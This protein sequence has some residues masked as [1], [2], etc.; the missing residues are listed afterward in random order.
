[1][2]LTF[3]E[4][5]RS[6]PPCERPLFKFPTPIYE[7]D[8]DV[9]TVTASYLPVTAGKVILFTSSMFAL[10]YAAYRGEKTSSL[11]SIEYLICVDRSAAGQIFWNHLGNQICYLSRRQCIIHIQRFIR[12][13]A[14]MLFTHPRKARDW[15]KFFYQDLTEGTSWLSSDARFRKIQQIFANQHFVFVHGD[16][17]SSECTESIAAKLQEKGLLL[18]AV[19]ISN[20]KE[21]AEAE[22]LLSNL[23]LGLSQ[24]LPVV[25]QDTYLIDTK[26][27]WGGIHHHELLCQ[28]IRPFLRLTLEA[29]PSCAIFHRE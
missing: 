27:R 1:M 17:S 26:T 23:R 20:Y 7:E 19:Y 25:N 10:N 2:Q 13:N 4:A 8:Q 28:R 15:L 12:K 5:F 22:G 6:I 16:L 29:S 21:L 3:Q 18:D 11:H 9:S 14:S 24:L